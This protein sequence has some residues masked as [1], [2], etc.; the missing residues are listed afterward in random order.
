MPHF[1]LSLQS[2]SDSVLKSMKRKYN[3]SQ[4]YAVCERLRSYIPDVQLTTDIIVGFPGETD[5]M[6]METLEFAKKCEFSHVHIFPY[7][8][9]EGTP[10][11]AMK[12][13][14]DKSV[15][16]VRVSELEAE[17]NKVR[18]TILGRYIG[19]NS[20]VL[21]ETKTDGYIDG[22]LPSYI[23]VIIPLEET[24]DIHSGEIADVTIT[25]TAN[26]ADGTLSL[27]GK[28]I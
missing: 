22:Y 28:I 14:I 21:L 19:T 2:G 26:D 12:G 6:F 17:M 7:S 4:F 18:S 1:H 23:K 5:E 11:A 16:K 15:Q 9:R 3:T 10:A 8:K 24:S 25:G 13:Q 27:V 20:K